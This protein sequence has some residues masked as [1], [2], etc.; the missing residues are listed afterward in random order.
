MLE[1]IDLEKCKYR[2]IDLYKSGWVHILYYLDENHYEILGKVA[3]WRIFHDE[4]IVNIYENCKNIHR[5]YEFS[6]R[7]H[8]LKVDED[9]LREALT[10]SVIAK[11]HR[12]VWY[13]CLI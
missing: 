4:D 6:K 8:E 11:S 1:K 5:A 12:E 9:S 3:V 7:I 13:D 10:M 2:C